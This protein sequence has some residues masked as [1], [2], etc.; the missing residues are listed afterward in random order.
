MNPPLFRQVDARFFFC[1][2]RIRPVKW[3]HLKEECRVVDPL[4]NPTCARMRCRN[5]PENPSTGDPGTGWKERPSHGN[6]RIKL[7]EFLIMTAAGDGVP[8]PIGALPSANLRDSDGAT[9]QAGCIL[10]FSWHKIPREP[11]QAGTTIRPCFSLT[12]INESLREVDVLAV[13]FLPP[14]RHLVV[15]QGFENATSLETL[16]AIMMICSLRR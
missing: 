10:A 2:R 3:C 8:G 7:I 16:L 5:K 1:W 6:Q 14:F 4:S 11:K 9:R 15:V 12:R 13:R